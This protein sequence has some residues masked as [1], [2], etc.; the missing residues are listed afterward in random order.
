MSEG[1]RRGR[2]D[3]G[4]RVDLDSIAVPF[5]LFSIEVRSVNM[6]EHPLAGYK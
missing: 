6:R 2:A 5:N 4:G 3:G 1:Y